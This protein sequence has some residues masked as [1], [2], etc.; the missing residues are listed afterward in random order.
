MLCA[1][2]LQRCL[3][4]LAARSATE[5]SHQLSAEGG[6]DGTNALWFDDTAD[7]KRAHDKLLQSAEYKELHRPAV[8][9][10]SMGLFGGEPGFE[11]S[12]R[13][14]VDPDRPQMKH[15][16]NQ[17]ALAKNLRYTRYGYFKRDM[18]LLDVD[19]L[20]RHARMLP[21]PNRLLGDFLYQRIPLPDKSC[22]AFLRY[23][24]DQM[25]LL[26]E[27]SRSS[28]F[29][30]AVEMFER[31]VVTNI[32]PV[33]VGVETHAELVRCCAVAKKW[34]EGWEVYVRRAR[35]MEE[36]RPD[37]FV[38][39]TDFYDAA[40]ELCVACARPSEGLRIL[41]ECISRHL[42]PRAGML[43]RAML[44]SAI[45]A[46]KGVG[47]GGA[48]SDEGSEVSIED[49]GSSVPLVDHA[50]YGLD[51]WALFDFYQIPRTTASVEAYMRLCSML[52]RPSLVLEALSFADASNLKPTLTCYQWAFY[53]IRGLQGFGDFLMDTMSQLVPR[54]L[55]PDYL[56][57]TVAY[58]YSAVQ[59]DGELALALYKQYMVYYNLNPTPEMTLLFLQ[60]CANC[61]EPRPEMLSVC[62]VMMD[63]LESVGSAVDHLSAIYDQYMELAAHLGAISSAFSKVKRLVSF[64]KPLTTRQMNSLLLANSNAEAPNGC[65]SMS[66]EVMKLFHL[67][68]LPAS[69][70]TITCLGLCQER[71][72][73]SDA[74]DDWMT[75]M[76]EARA[77]RADTSL[78]DDPDIPILQD[79]PHRLRQ[80][81]TAWMLRPRDTVLKRYGQNAKAA[82]ERPVGSMLGSVV[83]FGRTPGERN[84]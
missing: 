61:D 79:P 83:P 21:T 68:R 53:A 40:M 57:F 71:H 36:A 17:T 24:R 20:V 38:L 69:N 66:E 27:W 18:H 80:L 15:V 67:L 62:E 19:K 41:E 60:S 63:R 84:V 23:Q 8:T 42:R 39:S 10:S 55:T 74:L 26:D 73:T 51:A 76:T 29:D 72:G 3:A 70:D 59:R 11:K 30:C 64:G 28:S 7:S 37:A 50:Q 49:A 13:V 43:E 45:A 34:A 32:P 75:A 6:P 46:E 58:M 9:T 14:W 4:N 81:R 82:P 1:C 35:E 25:L 48:A 78:G 12:Y 31:M 56:L 2:R 33:E 52:R 5:Y 44:L 22:A 47:R 77:E 16:Y 65:V 54:G